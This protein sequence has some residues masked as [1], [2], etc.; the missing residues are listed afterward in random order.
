[1]PVVVTVAQLG[2]VGIASEVRAAIE[3]AFADRAGDWRVSVIGSQASERWELKIEGPNLFA[4][5]FGWR[6]SIGSD[7]GFS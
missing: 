4:R 6:A 5:G 2:N 7:S 1:M 3:H